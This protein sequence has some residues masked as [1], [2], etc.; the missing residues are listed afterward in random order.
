MPP[1]MLPNYLS[2]DKSHNCSQNMTNSSLTPRVRELIFTHNQLLMALLS[3]SGGNKLMRCP[4]ISTIRSKGIEN[5]SP[6]YTGISRVVYSLHDK[7]WTK[8]VQCIAQSVL[9]CDAH[10][11]KNLRWRSQ[12]AQLGSIPSGSPSFLSLPWPDGLLH[13]WEEGS[14]IH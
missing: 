7:H 10:L 6:S 1:S 4:C 8:I 12:W 5:L 9:D 11:P 13:G 2:I 3:A 14:G